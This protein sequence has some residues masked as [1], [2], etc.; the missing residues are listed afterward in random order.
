MGYI[1]EKTKMYIS[2]SNV[3]V[4]S[5]ITL[6]KNVDRAVMKSWCCAV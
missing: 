3:R 2:E 1:D 6:L 4:Y 5:K